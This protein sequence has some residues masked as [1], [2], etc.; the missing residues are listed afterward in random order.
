MKVCE[1]QICSLETTPYRNLFLKN[2]RNLQING[3]SWRLSKAAFTNENEQ[4]ASFLLT[5]PVVNQPS[6][7]QNGS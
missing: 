1:V 4:T 5:K 6:N 3:C 2:S 7:D